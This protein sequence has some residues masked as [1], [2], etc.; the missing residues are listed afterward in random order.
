MPVGTG[1]LKQWPTKT[2]VTSRAYKELL[3][4]A[5][6]I[7]RQQHDQVIASVYADAIRT[8]GRIVTRGEI[9]VPGT[10]TLQSFPATKN[11]PFHFRKTF[12][13]ESGPIKR[14][15]TPE[16]EFEKTRVIQSLL[17]GK[18]PIPLGFDRWTF[19]SEAI[20][21]ST[22]QAHS[23]FSDLGYEAS[24]QLQPDRDLL[25]IYAQAVISVC[26][27]LDE[28]HAKGYVH[29]DLTLHNA[30]SVPVGRQIRPVLIDLASSTALNTLSPSEQAEAIADDFSEL[31]RDLALIQRFTGEMADPHAC[32]S[33]DLV[34]DL[35]PE[36]IAC[37]IKQLPS[38]QNKSDRS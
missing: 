1:L 12:T 37:I 17:P 15:E 22:L 2:K 38:N 8:S 27:V 23:P 14:G 21:G 7:G 3:N 13:S 33:L 5:S 35:F 11:F 28:L 26:S 20:C 9:V 24:L 4:S 10:N 18:T 16:V 25:K 30:M 31:Y 29:G 36:E 6:R 32:R 19:R 34:E